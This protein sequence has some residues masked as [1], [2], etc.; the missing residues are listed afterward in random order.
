ME[1]FLICIEMESNKYDVIVL[2]GGA[3]GLTAEIYL[4]RA[5]IK[6][7]ILNESMVGGQIV[8]THEIANYPG[9]RLSIGK[10]HEK[11]S[12]IFWLWY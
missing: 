9:F 6:T 8:L 7:L 1:L 5:K 11:T 2:G 4:S 12:S 10:H 3:A